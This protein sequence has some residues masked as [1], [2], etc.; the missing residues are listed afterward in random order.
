[1]EERSRATPVND[2]FLFRRRREASLHFADSVRIGRYD[3]RYDSA[4]QARVYRARVHRRRRIDV[5]DKEG[6][7]RGQS[8]FWQH[9]R[10]KSVRRMDLRMHDIT[11]K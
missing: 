4:E 8:K 11:L 6:E 3:A 2:A 1:M 7:Q 9:F 10:L 5:G